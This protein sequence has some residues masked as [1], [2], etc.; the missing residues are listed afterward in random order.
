MSNFTTLFSGKANMEK[1]F[2]IVANIKEI[3]LK[4][5]S[6]SVQVK[7]FSSTFCNFYISYSSARL[8]REPIEWS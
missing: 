8:F 2:L 5:K 3:S 7:G 6:E 4:R 1:R